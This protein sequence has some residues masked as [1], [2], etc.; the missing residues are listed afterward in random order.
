MSG[1][2]RKEPMRYR[3]FISYSHLDYAAAVDL[4]YRLERYVLPSATRAAGGGLNYARQPL[5]P[6]FRDE[7]E[8]VPGQ[9]LPRRIGAA[10]EASEYLLVVC[11]P[12]AVASPDCPAPTISTSSAGLSSGPSFGVSHAASGCAVLARSAQT[13]ASRAIR[14]L[15]MPRASR[16]RPPSPCRS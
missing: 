9:D 13:C 6:I 8:L 4:H 5:R 11:S 15:F 7:A 1:A 16:H 10:L 3:A 12:N 14:A 2:G